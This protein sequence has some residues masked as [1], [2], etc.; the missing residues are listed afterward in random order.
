MTTTFAAAQTKLTAK[1]IDK[2]VKEMTLEEK[3]HLLVGFTFGNTYWGLPTDPD[4]NAK[5]IVLGAAGNT[6]N[7]DR[8]GIPHT[9]L[10]D[11]P[12][13]VHIAA[14]RPGDSDTYY[15]TGFPIGTVLAST[16][17][18]DLV[19]N[20]GKAMGDEAKE[21]G[22]D[23]LLGP[24]MNL[25]RSPL[26]GRNFEYYSE[27]P[28]LTGLIGAAMING[29]Q[30]EGVAVSAKHFAANSQES[31]RM[32]NNAVVDQR[33]LR[34]LYLKGFE[35]AVRKSQP[36]T[37]MSSYNKINGV[38]TQEDHDLLETI[39]R[40]EWGFKGIVMTDWTNTRNSA[41]QVQAGNDLLTPGNKEQK[42]Q[43]I[44][45]VKE[46]K[47]SMADVDR[48]VKRILEYVVKTP[49]FKGYKYSNKPDLEAHAALIRAAAPEG[50]V[51]LKNSPFVSN[52]QRG[53][54]QNTELALPLKGTEKVA[55]FG[56]TS[57]NLYAGGS[58]SGDV[59]KPYT[60][61][62]LTGLKG[63]GF[64]L[65]D[66]LATV[67]NKY[68]AYALDE[69][70][71]EM[72]QF[73]S[74]GFFPRPRV[75]EPTFGKYTYQ[76]AAQR[77]EIAIVT[78]GRSSGEG[79]D[80]EFSDF[81][82]NPDELAMLKGVSEAF[83]SAG[84]KVVVILNIGATIETEP[85]KEY[86]DAI[87]LAWQPGMEAG[88]SIADV[89]TGKSYPSGKL[90]TTFPLALNDVPS[91]KNFPKDFNW[92]D[93]IFMKPADVDALPNLG[94]T[95]YEE[96]LN[97]G[98]R[99]F[100]TAGKMVSY[101]FGFGLSYTTFEYSKAKIQKK[102]DKYVAT[103]TV[104][105]TGNRAGKEA[106]QLYVTAPKGKLQ[107][108]ALELKA[109]GKTRELQP[110]ESTVVTMTFT[111]YDLA[112]Y[113]M[114]QQAFVTDAG[115]YTAHFAAAADDIRQDVTFKASAKTVKCHDVMKMER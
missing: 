17:N 14:T 18:T 66:T 101:P 31:N 89:L 50:M 49:R 56:M 28:F 75:A 37:I 57:Y 62:L 52:P 9:V 91:T 27:D 107:K 12:A 84:K 32:R 69:A 19:Y 79:G 53:N 26:C 112:S 63:A 4:P 60:I 83:R 73:S 70:E 34:E 65:D 24:G 105:N 114:D 54:E 59:N 30:S 100:Q 16:W 51:L 1:N 58:G 99:Y 64:V 20:M 98:Y 6:A 111:N 36:W 86:A 45:G 22:V 87:L 106:V 23:C 113:D 41:A 55:L 13:G 68:K 90:T 46:G 103:V 7:V 77:C 108:P 80:R 44:A 10:S 11:G 47:I 109:F 78:V 94:E 35:I 33:T 25:M 8:F 115:T 72:G 67:Y 93:D 2:V 42:D 95:K 81:V 39:L 88:N 104:T 82:I 85:I 3:A 21:Y 48:N 61:D 96:G 15:A 40:K 74:N 43:I 5:A 71:A 38:Y 102:G 97:V 76:N 110:G 92:R 29:I